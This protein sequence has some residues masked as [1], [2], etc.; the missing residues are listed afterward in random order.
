MPEF[1]TVVKF[2]DEDSVEAVPTNWIIDGKCYWPPFHPNKLR[3]AIQKNE[4]ANTQW[5][6]YKV[7]IFRNSTF[8]NYICILYM[9]IYFTVMLRV[10]LYYNVT[11]VFVS[12][13]HLF[14][15]SHTF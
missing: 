1:W 14:S 4:A 7:S 9:S 11:T 5:P 12:F 15:L 13:I 10:F 8:G 3:A 6:L 2:I